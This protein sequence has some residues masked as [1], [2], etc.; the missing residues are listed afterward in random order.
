VN[1]CILAR[2]DWLVLHSHT[3]LRSAFRRGGDTQEY[4]SLTNMNSMP[5]K[6]TMRRH[7]DFHLIESQAI[8]NYIDVVFV[9][10]GPALRTQRSDAR[11]S[12]RV[13][14]MASFAASYVFPAVEHGVVK[15]RLKMQQVKASLSL[16]QSRACALTAI[17][18]QCC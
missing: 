11:A 3:D 8:A 2:R 10:A 14:E 9:D 1:A 4:G 16:R 5:S 17:A 7:G 13:D 6:S 12:A 18:T 15:P